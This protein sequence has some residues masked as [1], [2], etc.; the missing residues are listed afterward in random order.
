MFLLKKDFFGALSNNSSTPGYPHPPKIF[1]H[2]TPQPKIMPHP[3]PLTPTLP[4]IMPHTH[5]PTASHPKKYH[6]H[7]QPPNTHSLKIMPHLLPLTQNMV[8][9][10]TSTQFSLITS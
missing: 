10:P 3:P 2:P 8:Q 5:S 6:T 1:S 4:K 9:Q 7:P